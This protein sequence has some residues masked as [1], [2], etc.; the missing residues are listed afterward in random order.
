M[1]HYVVVDVSVSLVQ[2]HSKG[3]GKG[4]SLSHPGASLEPSWK[5]E[6]FRE[7]RQAEPVRLVG[8]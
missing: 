1:Q 6:L 2:G 4:A 8:H 7:L 5:Q 3:K